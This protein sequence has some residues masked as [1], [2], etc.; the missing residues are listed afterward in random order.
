MSFTKIMNFSCQKK[1]KIHQKTNHLCEGNITLRTCRN[2]PNP[3]ARIAI[4]KFP[5][6]TF[7]SS[8]KQPYQ[9]KWLVYISITWRYFIKH[10][11]RVQNINDWYFTLP[12]NLVTFSYLR[13]KLLT[14]WEHINHVF[15]KIILMYTCMWNV[16]RNFS[17]LNKT[18]AI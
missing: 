2:S 11:R 13:I 1:K 5:A 8:S 17:S 7:Q 9:C 12:S 4:G 15:L 6:D 3:R 10:S 16:N 18:T 14:L